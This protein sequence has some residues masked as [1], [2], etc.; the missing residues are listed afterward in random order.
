MFLDGLDSLNLFLKFTSFHFLTLISDAGIEQEFF[1]I[2]REHYEQ[3]PD[4]LMTKRTLQGSHPP[5]NQQFSDHY[6]APMPTYGFHIFIF[7]IINFNSINSGY[8]VIIIHKQNL[9]FN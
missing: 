1:I 3:R 5:K 2:S 8:D 7:Y 9:N 6:Y 4:L